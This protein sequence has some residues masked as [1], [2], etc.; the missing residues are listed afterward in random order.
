LRALTPLGV[1]ATLM[2]NLRS[3][4]TFAE[5]ISCDSRE[6]ELGKIYLTN[7]LDRLE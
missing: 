3:F 7:S 2:A 6:M 4:T 1:I 5:A